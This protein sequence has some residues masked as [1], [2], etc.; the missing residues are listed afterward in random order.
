MSEYNIDAK[1]IIVI[2]QSFWQKKKKAKL[3][4]EWAISLLSAVK[5]KRRKSKKIQ[6][7]HFWAGMGFGGLDNVQLR[8]IKEEEQ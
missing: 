3:S 2:S 8:F 4:K 5:E 6:T 1:K 7:F